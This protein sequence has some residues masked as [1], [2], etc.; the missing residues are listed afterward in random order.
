MQE[1]E[2]KAT[3]TYEKNIEFLSKKHPSVFQ[4]INN[5][6]NEIANGNYI[7]QYALDYIDE[8]FDVLQKESG[9][10]LY[11]GNSI[12]ISQELTNRVNY[13]KDSY[14]FDGF[15]LYYGFDK[16]LDELDD[17][18][19][20]LEGIYPI[21]TYYLD[22]IKTSDEMRN[23]EKF[24]FIGVGLG[25]HIFPI[26]KKISSD[27]YLIIE[28]DLELFRLSLFTTPYYKMQ[29]EIKITF[30]I[31]EDDN[32]F[33]NSI[34]NFLEISFFRNKYL[35][36]SFFPAHSKHKI[37]L[38]QNTLAAQ[39]FVSFP[40]KIL[41][42]KV[43]KP[44]DFINSGY[45][46]LN[47]SK[48]FEDSKLSNKPILV[49]GAGPS[50]GKNIQWLKDNQEYFI[51]MAVSSTLK[52][53]SQ[54]NIKPDIVTHL[55]GFEVA[56]DLF[57]GFNAK[58]F[59]TDSI[60][61]LG[62]FTPDSVKKFFKKEN[63][64]FTEEGTYYNNSFN[65]N[66]GPCVGSTSIMHSIILNA[67]N[68][69]ILG[70]DLSID[71]KTGK[72]HS[73][74]HVTTDKH[75]LSEANKLKSSMSF[76]GNIFPVK[77]NFKQQVFTNPL[78]Q[79][80]IQTLYNK[81]PAIKKEYQNIYNLNDGA[82]LEQTIPLHIKDIDIK[83]FESI[84]KQSVHENMLDTLQKYSV[85][86]LSQEDID[87]LKGRLE[88]AKETKEYILDYKNIISYA[89]RDKYLYD[90]IG[91]T[92]KILQIPNRE[93]RNLLLV[94]DMFLSYSLPIIMD[95]F[96]TKSL[97]NEKRHMKKLDNMIISELLEIESIYE[98]KIENF[99]K[100]NN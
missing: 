22:N 45:N 71:E 2:Q 6:E 9:H 18:S 20:G 80:S 76:R 78:F 44:L 24:M 92:L 98:T 5:L 36:Y 42:N 7:E 21:M 27:E 55:D 37:K 23:I 3:R 73:Q 65:T 28:N 79:V 17:K 13:K 32:S 43:L 81:I 10:Y 64:F 49:I 31:S 35:K 82:Y 85:R 46:V 8:Y 93:S 39:D 89:N 94:Y 63:T 68:I 97:K 70:I 51:I 72:T 87:S 12:E 60:A 30:S 53:L 25:L 50:L 100:E 16:H 57:K 15:P 66:T 90:L 40:Y 4:K 67:K 19:K 69:Y 61:I 41:L 84:N 52:L 62:S 83:R 74:S 58:E 26:H 29:D 1:I 88:F 14:I 95:F 47:M 48:H 54:H 91:L 33:I 34:N 11:S 56:L 99:L 75:D 59:L 77:G 96:N 38:I 86:K